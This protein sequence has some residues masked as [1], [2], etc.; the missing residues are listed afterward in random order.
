LPVMPDRFQVPPEKTGSNN[1]NV[2]AESI[3]GTTVLIGLSI[4]RA[5]RM[6]A[7]PGTFPRAFMN[8]PGIVAHSIELLLIVHKKREEIYALS[9][10]LRCCCSDENHRFAVPA[11]HRSVS[12]P[13]AM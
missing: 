2:I 10:L 7:S 9:G 1:L 8:P 3:G 13:C 12:L 11:E 4:C 6:A 5:A